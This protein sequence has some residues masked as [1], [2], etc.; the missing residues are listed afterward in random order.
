MYLMYLHNLKSDQAFSSSSQKTIAI[1]S[2]DRNNCGSVQEL[3]SEVEEIDSKG[4]KQRC[5][6]NV[7]NIIFHDEIICPFCGKLFSKTIGEEEFNKQ[8]FNHVQNC[9]KILLNVDPFEGL[10][11]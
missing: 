11:S 3:I 8:F 4:A 7:V 6:N 5:E 9:K 10:W 1:E 2:D